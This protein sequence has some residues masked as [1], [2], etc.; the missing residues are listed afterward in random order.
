MLI[1]FLGGM[2][3][4][5]G[6]AGALAAQQPA[7]G[8]PSRAVS[9]APQTAF[10]TRSAAT[11]IPAP[12][13]TQGAQG[14]LTTMPQTLSP[15]PDPAGVC[16]PTGCPPL[17]DCGT[18]CDCLC[19][20][21]GKYWASAEWLFWT[22]RGQYIPPLVTSSPPGTARATAGVLGAPTTSVLYGGNRINDEWRSGF[23]LNAGMWLDE[24][25]RFG[26]EGNFFF[27]GQ[28]HDNF[29]VGSNGSPILARPFN[30]ALTQQPASQLVAA[31]SQLVAFPGVL[32]GT[33]AVNSK[34]N[35][36]GGGVNFVRNLCCD[37]CGRLDILL[38]YRYLNLRDEVTINENLTSLA[39]SNVPANTQFLI[40]DRFRTTNQFHGAL[41]GLNYERRFSHFFFGVRPSVSL[42]VTNTTVTIDGSTTIITPQG[43]PTTYPG[44][45]YTQNTNIGRYSSSRFSVVPEIGVRAGVQLTEHMRAFVSYNF[46]YWSGVARAG[47]QIDTRVNTNQ[48]APPSSLNGPALPA[49]ELRRTDY[50]VQGIGVGLEL[51]Y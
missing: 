41:L 27:L 48:I 15:A 46:L 20:P 23:R 45:L 3:A 22:A 51:R 33:V 5:L 34:S 16:G 35:L 43:V 2:T 26:I 11:Q 42:G 1:R 37:P 47:E 25:Q 24:C 6:V 38:G 36:I 31:D 49:Y 50:W 17:P 44:G 39:G 29:T 30:N 14:T 13:P 28:S 12:A 9:S 40:Q 18:A 8:V 32:S 19:G 21:P 4:C 10:P 7:A